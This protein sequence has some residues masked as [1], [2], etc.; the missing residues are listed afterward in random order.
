M[1]GMHTS[2]LISSGTHVIH[3]HTTIY[4]SQRMHLRQSIPVYVTAFVYILHAVHLLMYVEP[5]HA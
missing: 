3:E 1:L 5:S 2:T 4:V